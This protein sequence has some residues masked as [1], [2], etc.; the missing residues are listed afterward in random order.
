M[1]TLLKKSRR[2]VSIS[3]DRNLFYF[4]PDFLS[5]ECEHHI[6]GPFKVTDISFPAHATF[7]VLQT[8]E[9][10]FHFATAGGADLIA[11][12]HV[13]HLLFFMLAF[14]SICRLLSSLFLEQQKDAAE[15]MRSAASLYCFGYV[16]I[17]NI[18]SRV[19]SLSAL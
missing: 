1:P 12:S 13:L 4:L 3:Y 16:Q 5:L 10:L 15:A 2:A 18:R 7:A 19:I 17:C 9:L 6:R 8:N 11:F 14:Y